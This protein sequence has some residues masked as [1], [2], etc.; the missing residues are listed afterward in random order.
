MRLEQQ[1]RKDAAIA[2]AMRSRPGAATPNNDPQA[3]GQAVASSPTSGSSVASGSATTA[4]AHASS[5][6]SSA[7]SPAPAPSVAGTGNGPGPAATRQFL[8]L[9][10]NGPN[11]KRW[12][13]VE[14]PPDLNDTA[15]FDAVRDEYA[16]LRKSYMRSFDHIASPGVLQKIMQ[17]MVLLGDR[18]WDIVQVFFVPQLADFVKARTRG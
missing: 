4:P 1:L 6:P 8:L 10:V 15:L 18:C 12:S 11:H 14:L 2:A 3:S 9:C 5:G 13:N 7:A 16:K 17:K